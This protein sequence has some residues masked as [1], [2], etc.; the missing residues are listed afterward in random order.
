MTKLN[1]PEPCNAD[2]DEENM[3]EDIMEFS[4]HDEVEKEYDELYQGYK[5]YTKKDLLNLL[6]KANI[7]YSPNNNKQM[8]I[9][10]LIR[11]HEHTD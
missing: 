1:I 11:S 7:I 4:V 2:S 9:E 3:D 10:R 6:K 5:N 8:L